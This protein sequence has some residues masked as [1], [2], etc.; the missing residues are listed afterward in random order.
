MTVEFK[1][2]DK[3]KIEKSS[4]YYSD[5]WCLNPSDEVGTVIE[6]RIARITGYTIRVQWKAG[7]NVYRP[8]DLKMDKAKLLIEEYEDSYKDVVILDTKSSVEY[9]YA[10]TSDGEDVQLTEKQVKKIR[11]QLKAWLDNKQLSA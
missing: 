7:V 8:E 10:R 11:K 9:V 4:E 3:V 6:V 2:G 5:D 1:V